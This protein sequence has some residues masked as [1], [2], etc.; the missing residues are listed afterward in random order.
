M[1]R[2]YFISA[3]S[4]GRVSTDHGLGPRY[5]FS[6]GRGAADSDKGILDMS[7]LELRTVSPSRFVLGH[8][9]ICAV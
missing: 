7:M 6:S 2:F 4:W 3:V 8:S 1:L 5:G 9:Q